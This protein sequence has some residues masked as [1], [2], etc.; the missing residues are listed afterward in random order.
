MGK[1]LSLVVRQVRGAD[2]REH[3]PQTVRTMKNDG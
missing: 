3:T 2:R 1:I